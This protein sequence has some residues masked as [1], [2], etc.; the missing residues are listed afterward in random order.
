MRARLLLSLGLA[1]TLVI[2]CRT[3]ESPEGQ[4][5]D[6][7]IVAQIKSKLASEVGP[8]TVTNISVNATNRIVTLAGQVNSSEI[9]AK[10]ELVAREVPKV[11]RVINNLQI[12]PRP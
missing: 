6:L 10:S 4:V 11:D 9:K 3:N 1:L 7:K 12:T 5:T 2:G 8:S